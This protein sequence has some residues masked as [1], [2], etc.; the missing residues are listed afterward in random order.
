MSKRSPG[1]ITTHPPLIEDSRTMNNGECG[2]LFASWSPGRSGTVS[3]GIIN[4]GIFRVRWCR[5]KNALGGKKQQ[6]LQRRKNA[7]Q[8]IKSDVCWLIDWYLEW[9]KWLDQRSPN[10]T[11][12]G[13]RSHQPH[14]QVS[15]SNG[16]IVAGC[17]F[18]WL[19]LQYRVFHAAG[20]DVIS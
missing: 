19:Q 14:E 11:W 13:S 3:R 10:W 17:W 8:G 18:Q 7:L 4:R 1:Q 2:W 16:G 9:R 6:T 20:S 5:E 15:Q 12:R